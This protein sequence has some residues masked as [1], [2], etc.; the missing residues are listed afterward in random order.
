MLG[1]FWKLLL[2]EELAAALQEHVAT[3]VVYAFT[4]GRHFQLALGKETEP[5]ALRGMRVRIGGRNSGLL[6]GRKAEARSAVI[7]AEMDRMIEENP[8]LKPTRAA[9]LAHRKGYGTSAEANRK[10]W[11]RRKEKSGT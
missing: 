7:L 2:D 6:G 8:H 5:D 10:L 3:A 9:A 1:R 4:A 11:N